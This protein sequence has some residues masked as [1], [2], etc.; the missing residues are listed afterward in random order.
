MLGFIFFIHSPLFL[1]HLIYSH[2]FIH[3]LYVDISQYHTPSSP[4]LISMHNCLLNI[5]TWIIHVDLKQTKPKFNSSSPSCYFPPKSFPTMEIHNYSSNLLEPETWKS[6]LISPP[7]VILLTTNYS[8]K[9]Y[10]FYFWII[11]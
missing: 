3:H 6:S 11:S 4:S 1:G 8:T 9:C 10:W 7:I 5:P 2:G